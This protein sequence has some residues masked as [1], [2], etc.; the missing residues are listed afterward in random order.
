MWEPKRAF[1]PKKWSDPCFWGCPVR[2]RPLRVTTARVPMP[3]NVLQKTGARNDA[4]AELHAF[5]TMHFW[6]HA[7]HLLHIVPRTPFFYLAHWPCS[8]LSSPPVPQ[9]PEDLR[10][11][12]VKQLCTFDWLQLLKVRMISGRGLV[13]AA[14]NGSFSPRYAGRQEFTSRAP[15]PSF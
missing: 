14:G 6:G 5:F 15:V 1:R 4:W 11:L 3:F 10:Q 7:L 12:H 8:R 2:I 9:C 13:L